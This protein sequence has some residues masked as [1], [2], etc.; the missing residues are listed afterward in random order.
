MSIKYIFFIIAIQFLTLSTASS[1]E[2]SP[3]FDGNTLKIP[4]IDSPGNLGTYQDVEFKMRCLM[5][6]I[7]LQL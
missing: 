5:L 4:I 1:K 2:K 6:K 7:E 3:I